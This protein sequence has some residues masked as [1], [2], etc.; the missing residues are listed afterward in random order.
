MRVEPQ[1]RGAPAFI[2][3]VTSLLTAASA[4]S[5]C[6]VDNDP[7]PDCIASIIVS[8]SLPRTSPTICRVRL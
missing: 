2:A 7:V 5:A 3:Q 6:V 8:A 4:D 1:A